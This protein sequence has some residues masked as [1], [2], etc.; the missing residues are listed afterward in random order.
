MLE[1]LTLGTAAL[2]IFMALPLFFMARQRP[3]NAFLGFFVFGI[4]MLAIS[5][6]CTMREYP[7]FYPHLWGVFDWPATGI[8][9]AYYCYV[10]GMLGLGNTRKQ[11]WH[12]LPMLVATL[13]FIAF[14]LQGRAVMGDGT[15]LS[16]RGWVWLICFFVAQGLAIFYAIAV[17]VRFWQ[18]RQ[19]VEQN[20]SSYKGRDFRWLVWIS[21]MMLLLLIVWVLPLPTEIG[22]LAL[23]LARLGM[24][25][26]VG[27]FG[28]GQLPVFLAVPAMPEAPTPHQRAAQAVAASVERAQEAADREANAQPESEEEASSDKY[29]RSGMTD[30]ARELIAQRLQQRMQQFNDFLDNDLSLASLAE[31]IGTSPQLLSQYLNHS[32]ELSFFDYINGLRVERVQQLML[33]PTQS[34]KTIIQLAF[35]AGF[36]SKSTFNLAFKKKTSYSP[37]QWRENQAKTSVPI[38]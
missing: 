10:R 4:A 18:Y 11:A 33:D 25:Y 24:L 27:W 14:N 16:P 19:Q 34:K 2:G 21:S 32:L 8:G 23:G 28:M 9:A 6:L 5:D 12:F 1:V 17:L 20:F 38:G 29:A 13:F 22:G 31:N 3:A 37:S 35:A 26:F 7:R 36:N 30:A 15:S